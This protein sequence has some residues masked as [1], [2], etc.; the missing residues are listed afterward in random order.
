MRD[1]RRAAIFAS[2][3]V[4]MFFSIL[5]AR[6]ASPLQ[7]T[8]SQ[9]A[10]SPPNLS[11][12]WAR[13]PGK[14]PARNFL[15]DYKAADPP[16]TP[17]TE[18]VFKAIKSSYAGQTGYLNDPVFSCY[19]P[20]VPRIYSVDLQG[21]M[22]IIQA[23][24]RVLLLYEYDHYVRQVYTD[25]RPHQLDLPSTWMGDSIGKWEGETLVVDTVGFNDKTRLDKMGHPHSDA[26]HVVERIRRVDR[27]HLQIGI[28]IDDPKAYTKPWG[29][30][31]DFTYEPDWHLE[32]FA[33]QDNHTFDEFREKSSTEPGK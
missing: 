13:H 12:V 8:Q 30:Q 16:M 27:D 1:R 3:I 22:E 10:A 4:L 26:L 14:G 28:T 19:P 33:C 2:V 32:E 11:G 18:A 20:G 21:T 17:S 6:P 29:G 15:A 9:G 25:G 31:L 23:P 5:L 24:G 7:A